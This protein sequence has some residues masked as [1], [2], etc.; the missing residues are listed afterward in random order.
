MNKIVTENEKRILSQAL[1]DLNL[2]PEEFLEIIEGKR[3]RE[4]PD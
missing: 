2:A 4:W 3:T 1:W